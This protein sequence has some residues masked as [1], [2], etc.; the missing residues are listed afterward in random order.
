MPQGLGRVHIVV[1]G[2]AEALAV[3]VPFLEDVRGQVDF[4]PLGPFQSLPGLQ[5]AFVDALQGLFRL[6]HDVG[7]EVDG[8]AV[9]LAQQEKAQGLGQVA[10]QD[11]ADGL[12]VAQ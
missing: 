12:E 6:V 5:L 1:Q 10:A 9:M 2:S 7:G 11:I 4:F 3:I 8:A